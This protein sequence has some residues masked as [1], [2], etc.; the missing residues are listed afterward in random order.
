MKKTKP[1]GG[2]SFAEIL[3]A[4]ALLCIVIIPVFPMVTQSARNS[5]YSRR[6]YSAQ[7]QAQSI[8]F[9]V[10]SATE[11]GIAPQL[12]VEGY[13]L[14]LPPDSNILLSYGYWLNG[15]LI[16][17]TPGSPDPVITVNTDI[18]NLS[19]ITVIIW[20]DNG[21]ISGRASG[22]VNNHG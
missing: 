1:T 13:L 21:N 6:V 16:Y 10:R 14:S 17:K 12:L 3:I 22:L 2:L 4:A 5:E 11:A 8:M 18:T 15:N 20:D 19:V 7:L 9:I